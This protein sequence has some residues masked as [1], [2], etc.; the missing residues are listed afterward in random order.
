MIELLLLFGGALALTQAR[1]VSSPAPTSEEKEQAAAMAK[2]QASFHPRS[3]KAMKDPLK[4][5]PRTA[6]PRPKIDRSKAVV[7]T[8]V[9]TQCASPLGPGSPLKVCGDLQ[10]MGLSRALPVV[11]DVTQGSKAVGAELQKCLRGVGFK[12]IV[13]EG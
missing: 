11:V 12:N 5:P 4:T 3:A 13:V 6:P 8:V 7:I 9:G 2:Q 1:K 10:K